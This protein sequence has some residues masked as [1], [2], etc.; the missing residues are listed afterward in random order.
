MIARLMHRAFVTRAAV[1]VCGSCAVA[2]IN[3]VPRGVNAARGAQRNWVPD[4]EKSGQVLF[5]ANGALATVELY[6]ADE[7]KQ[8]PRPS[9]VIS[10]GITDPVA[11][12]VG[13]AG[14][15]YVA[16]ATSA[17]EAA[18]V[19]MGPPGSA[20]PLPPTRPVF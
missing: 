2:A 4:A 6:R 9:G 17:N 13:R 11:L 15:L 16:N 8:V 7:N 3:S 5:V 12:A 1:G 18:N 10:N 14:D 19:E 20:H